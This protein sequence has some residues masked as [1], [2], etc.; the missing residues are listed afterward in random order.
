MLFEESEWQN[1]ADADFC[2]TLTLPLV[3]VIRV[4]YESRKRSAIY[5]TNRRVLLKVKQVSD[6]CKAV[7]VQGKVDGDNHY[8]V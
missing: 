8:C 6:L 7:S 3:I 1:D 5:V 4:G 2:S